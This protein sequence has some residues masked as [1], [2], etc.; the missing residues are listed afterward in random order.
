MRTG[1]GIIDLFM[2]SVVIPALNEEKN[3]PS[4]LGSLKA[5]QWTGALEVIVVDNGS[6]DDT[7][8]VA[9]SH[10]ATV[11]LC[12]KR[13]VAYARQAGAEAAR[14]EIIAQADA[15][16]VYPPGWLGR[17]DGYFETHQDSAGLAGRYEYTHPTWWVPVER[18]YRKWLNALGYL[19]FR[20]PASVSGA[21]FAFR[22]SAFVRARGY[23]PN[24]L[25]PDQWG[26]ARRVSRFGRV[27]YDHSSV[28]ITSPRRVAKPIYVIGCEIVRNCCHVGWHFVKHCVRQMKQSTSG[29]EAR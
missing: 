4:C 12:S 27:E 2:I 18:V 20:W 19:F 1:N 25:Y 23:D 11:V 15:D 5:Q 7:S 26:I 22:R 10:G 16:T 3:L 24:S 21:N 8:A 14:G 29:P 28:V 6:T 13:G 9:S 17:I